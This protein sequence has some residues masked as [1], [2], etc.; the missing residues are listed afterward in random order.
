[1]AVAL[2]GC[3]PASQWEPVPVSETP[4]SLSDWHVLKVSGGKL[5]VRRDALAYDLNTPLFTDYAH[6]FR[7]VWIP[8]GKAARYRAEEVFDFPVG[9]VITKTFYYPDAPGSDSHPGGTLDA[10]FSDRELERGE[11]VLDAVRL[12][13]T[14]ILV[15]RMDGWEAL[16]YVWNQEET[17]AR[18][19]IAG[20][21]QPLSLVVGDRT[22]DFNYV[23]PTKNECA[24]CHATNHS[25]ARLQPIGPK[26]RNLNKVYE[27][28]PAGPADQLRTWQGRALLTGL[29][30]RG[31][32]PA[33]ALWEPGADDHLDLRARS[34]LD[35]NCGHCHNPVG[36]ADTSG[37][38]LHMAETDRR[39]LGVCK[40]PIAAGRGA[41]GRSMSIYPGEPARSILHFRIQSTDPAA[42]MP[43][44]G[45]S[46]V[47][48]EG[49]EL[50]EKWIAAMDPGCKGQSRNE[51][52][53]AV[54]RKDM[55]PATSV[56]VVRMM[57]DAVAGS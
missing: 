11:L 44:L 7:T 26:A 34:Y 30:G 13:E 41:G 5:R 1:M 57:E 48:R 22:H 9:T 54:P 33:A 23:V 29:P 20:D 35:V 24:S 28:Y 39:R 55:N 3:Q 43:E 49:V 37:L 52:S 38:F 47:H 21:I 32:V 6:K 25:T 51:S 16:P 45:R 46:L 19:S 36:A 15:R 10:A 27:H 2:A 50:I 4:R 14:R 8:A 42:M 31:E 56:T 40:P 53:V 12:I 17:E 18:L